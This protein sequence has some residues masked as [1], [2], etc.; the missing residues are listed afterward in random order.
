ML[1][2]PV[3]FEGFVYYQ[4]SPSSSTWYFVKWFETR[5][6][7]FTDTNHG[8]ID[9][10]AHANWTL[11]RRLF[12]STLQSCIFHQD[13]LE[14]HQ[15]MD[16]LSGLVVS[17]PAVYPHCKLLWQYQH[18]IV[19]TSPGWHLAYPCSSELLLPDPQ[20]SDLPLGSWCEKHDVY[21]YVHPLGT[22]F[23]CQILIILD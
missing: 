11:A 22:I 8:R 4:W 5:W 17:L 3:I 1:Y 2:V 12:A 13:R 16:T 14:S 10:A 23:S 18:L 21:N 20:S 6:A 9:E 19:C 15:Q 7:S